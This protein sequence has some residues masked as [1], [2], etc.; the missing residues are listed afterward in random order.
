LLRIPVR[1]DLV[2]K[3]KIVLGELSKACTTNLNV[4][5]FLEE[6]DEEDY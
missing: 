4:S 5:S 2:D 3:P 1:L 6:A